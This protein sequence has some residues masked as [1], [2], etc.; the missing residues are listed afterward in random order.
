MS[1]PGANSRHKASFCA[2]QN[3]LNTKDIFETNLAKHPGSLRSKF[4][5]PSTRLGVK[6]HPLKYGKRLRTIELKL[7]H[8]PAAPS[9]CS[10]QVCV[11]CTHG[12]HQLRINT[13]IKAGLTSERAAK[14]PVMAT[15][16]VVRTVVGNMPTAADSA[17]GAGA[18]AEA[19]IATPMLGT[20][21]AAT[22]VLVQADLMAEAIL[23]FEEWDY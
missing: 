3:V 9:F 22:K 4:Q 13:S 10:V 19:A 20:A 6:I 17:N 14:N 8:P 12:N 21:I 16:N 15:T 18:G 5:L 7:N 1:D 11:K 23:E 2:D